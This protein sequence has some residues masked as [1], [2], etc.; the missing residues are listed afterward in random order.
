MT[1]YTLS[2]KLKAIRESCNKTQNQ[3]A[4]VLGVSRNTVSN[5]ENEITTPPIDVL[6]EYCKLGKV[7]LNYLIDTE[8]DT[9]DN[10]L[11]SLVMSCPVGIQ[12]KLLELLKEFTSK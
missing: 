1:N 2:Q 9:I 4:K 7:P 3:F 8:N 5:Y 11:V 12:N 6:R 10:E